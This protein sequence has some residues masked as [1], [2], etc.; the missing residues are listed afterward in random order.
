MATIFDLVKA[1][2]LVSYF[3]TLDK[4]RAPYLGEELFPA[5]KKLGLSLKWIKGSAGLPVVLKPSAFDTAAIPRPRI[6]FDSVQAEMPFFKESLYIDEELRQELNKVL[7]TGNQAYIDAVLGRVFNDT[8]RLIEGAGAQRE[9]MRMM[10]LTT[11]A[12]AIAA[13]GQAFTY[14]YGMPSDNKVDAAAKWSAATSN[15]I[16]DIRTLQDHIE[17][18]PIPVSLADL[19]VPE[20]IPVMLGDHM[21]SSIRREV[22]NDP[23]PFEILLPGMFAQFPGYPE[24]DGNW[25]SNMGIVDGQLRVQTIQD[26]SSRFGGIGVALSLVRSDGEIIHPSETLWGRAWED[27][28]P[29]PF[30]EASREI[31]VSGEFRMAPYS[32]SEYIFDVDLDNLDDY[33]LMFFGSV[34]MGVEGRW[35]VSVNTSD[36]AN[37]IITI[38]D[39]ILIMGH[40]VEFITLNPIGMQVRG[41]FDNDTNIWGGGSGEYGEFVAYVETSDGNI[42]LKSSGRGYINALSDRYD[43]EPLGGY[44]DWS[45]QTESPLDIS[46]VTAIIIEGVRIP[47]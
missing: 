13:N 30:M 44:F 15:I 33:Q 6:G 21:S 22:H 43:S 35:E 9:R 25:I 42:L 38:M 18:E 16:E 14:D 23:I 40:T 29:L 8:I 5:D 20:T 10:L 2:E 26:M 39:D 32:I 31:N 34:V 1:Q 47:V 4:D 17:N 36:T 19:A 7:E 45:W 46:T 12:I 37:Q 3:E 24:G 41:R 11:G 28:M 27:H